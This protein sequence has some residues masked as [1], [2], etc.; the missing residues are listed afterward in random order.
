MKRFSI[1]DVVSGRTLEIIAARDAKT[2]LK[3]FRARLM[4]SGC[5]EIRKEPEGWLLA[6]SYGAYFKAIEKKD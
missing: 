3:R 2:A 6:S 1:V 4:S 5:Y